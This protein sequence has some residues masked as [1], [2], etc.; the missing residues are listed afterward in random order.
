MQAMFLN[1]VYKHKKLLFWL[2]IFFI[3][4]QIFINI[5]HGLVFSPFYH[6]GMYS[7]VLKPEKT[8]SVPEIFIDGKQL[9]GK[10]FTP[11]T[12]DKILQPVTFYA[13]INTSNLLYKNEV[14]RLSHAFIGGKREAYF[15]QACNYPLFIE[16]YKKYLAMVT[17]KPVNEVVINYRT[18]AFTN[19]RLHPTPQ[20]I[21][22]Q[23]LCH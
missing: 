6:Y 3:F 2:M 22:L 20:T 4:G 9:M 10:D 12:W 7:Q 16:W 14:K 15:N 21:S 17:G 11:W 1:Q 19:N 13:S 23:G 8:Y 18:Y 5:K